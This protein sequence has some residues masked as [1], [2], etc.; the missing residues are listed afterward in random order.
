M[1]LNRHKNIFK[2]EDKYGSDQFV[3]T[4]QTNFDDELEHMEFTQINAAD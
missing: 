4:M 2:K 1:T 3:Q